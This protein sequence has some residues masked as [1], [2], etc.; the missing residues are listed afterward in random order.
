LGKKLV[1]DARGAEALLDCSAQATVF[2]GGILLNDLTGLKLGSLS[3]SAIQLRK[4][5]MLAT[6]LKGMGL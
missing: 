6:P 2:Y 3:V 1:A 5:T 4:P